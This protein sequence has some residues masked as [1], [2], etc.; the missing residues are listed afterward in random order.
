MYLSL[1]LTSHTK[2]N[3]ITS[4]KI[5][6]VLT[7]ET[8]DVRLSGAD[9]NSTGRVELCYEGEW[10]TVCDDSWDDSDARVVCRQLGLPTKGDLIN[11]KWPWA[12][13]Y[14]A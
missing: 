12:N 14:V 10:G 5:V 1:Y 13:N 7:C 2:L 4:T 8:G 9:K 3:P 6:V 11:M